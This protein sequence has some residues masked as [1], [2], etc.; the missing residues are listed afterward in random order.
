MSPAAVA[1]HALVRLVR[2]TVLPE[3]VT[4]ETTYRS[5]SASPSPPPGCWWPVRSPRPRTP[6]GTP[7]CGTTGWTSWPWIGGISAFT[8]VLSGPSIVRRYPEAFVV[9]PREPAHTA[10]SAWTTGAARRIPWP[11]AADVERHRRRW[12]LRRLAAVVVPSATA[13]VTFG[14]A[15]AV[16]IAAGVGSGVSDRVV[17][18]GRVGHGRGPRRVLLPRRHAACRRARSLGGGEGARGSARPLVSS[19]T[20][21]V[22]ADGPCGTSWPRRPTATSSV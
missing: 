12:A 7:G 22:D 15:L 8:A 11:T 20:R 14:A 3:D 18:L 19:G 17:R 6:S 21:G 4:S 10:G 9:P 2:H 16:L 13:V 5:S 1:D